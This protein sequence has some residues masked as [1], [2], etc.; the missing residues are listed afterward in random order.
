MSILKIATE[1]TTTQWCSL[2]DPEYV[3]STRQDKLGR[4]WVVY[5]TTEGQL[6]KI[7]MFL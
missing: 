6:V 7:H 1:I 2:K 5:K 4:Y 3:M